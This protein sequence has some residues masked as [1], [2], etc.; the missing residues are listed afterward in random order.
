MGSIGEYCEVFD[1][2]RRWS[3]GQSGNGR[4]RASGT[5]AIQAPILAYGGGFGDVPNDHYF[6]HKGVV[7]S[8]RSPKPH[9]PEMKRAY[10][11]IG[12]EPV[13]LRP[14]RLRSG[15]SI[16]SSRWPASM[17]SGRSAKMASKSN[18]AHSACR[19]SPWGP[20]LRSRSPS[21]HSN[22]NPAGS[23]S[24]VSLS[25][26]P[27]IELWAKKGYEV[28]A[29]QFLLPISAPAAVAAAAKPV[30][31]TQDDKAITAAGDG[32]TVIFDKATGTISASA[33]DSVNMLAGGGGPR[34]HLWRAPHRNDDMWAYKEWAKNGLDNSPSVSSISRPHRPARTR[35]AWL[36]KSRPWERTVSALRTMPCTRSTG[37]GAIAVDN[38]VRFDGPRCRSGGS[39]S[40]CCSTSGSTGS[41]SLVAD[42]W[43]ITR[44]ANAAST[45]A[46]TAP[47]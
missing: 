15:T 34:L 16:S 6:I 27:R 1:S 17:A 3:A 28:A 35:F 20:K 22:P 44:T 12:I 14:A 29:E 21:G 45:W 4:T 5:G 47:A 18:T 37:D 46:S 30:S 25:R 9:Y 43:K 8:D 24:S 26:W 42:R 33:R 11:W 41:T 13:D 10:Q 32:F 7:F 36:P 39:A 31:L 38:N 40:G 23:T 2:V 19:P